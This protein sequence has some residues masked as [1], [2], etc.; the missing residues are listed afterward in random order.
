M[1]LCFPMNLLSAVC[2]NQIRK[3]RKRSKILNTIV[4]QKSLDK[5]CRPRS[6]CFF[7][8]SL[9]RVFP[10]CYSD[11]HFWISNPENQHFIC[12]Q[13]EKSAKN[14]RT[15][16]VYTWSYHYSNLG[17]VTYFGVKVTFSSCSI[18]SFNHR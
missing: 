8:S 1:L 17:H 7:R 13:K 11:E 2:K 9:I 16:T 14:F 10:V 15:F 4:C 12:K 6:D 3:Y 18:S 5:Q